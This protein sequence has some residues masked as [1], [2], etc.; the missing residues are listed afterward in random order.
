MGEGGVRLIFWGWFAAAK[1]AGVSLRSHAALTQP[2]RGGRGGAPS[3]A[4][5]Q[6]KLNEPGSIPLCSS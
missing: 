6:E 5:H 3:R 4:N 1:P 2:A